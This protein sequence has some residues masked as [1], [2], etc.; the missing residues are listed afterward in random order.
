MASE[1]LPD[2]AYPPLC[3]VSLI[4]LLD[5]LAEPT[6]LAAEAL[7]TAFGPE[8]KAVD[9]SAD[10][11]GD[12]R[13]AV[14]QNILEDR[15]FIWTRGSLTYFWEETD[16]GRY[17]H[18]EAIRDGFAAAYDQLRETVGVTEEATSWG[19]SYT[20]RFRRGT[21][22]QSERDWPFCRL[23]SL[24]P[25]VLAGQ[26]NAADVTIDWELTSSDSEDDM[27]LSLWSQSQVSPDELF[28]ELT[29]SGPCEP[30][31]AALLQAFDRG[32]RTIVETFAELATPQASDYW[33]RRPRGR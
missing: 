22:W 2:Y 23:V 26:H 24:P 1:S 21:V 9:L 11:P 14:F 32:R 29:A 6:P 13:N 16:G 5:D 7:L 19:A 17:P 28:L 27:H 10:L 25:S 12:S 15:V 33:G 3:R 30:G 4:A 31:R 18:Y 20:N 8:W